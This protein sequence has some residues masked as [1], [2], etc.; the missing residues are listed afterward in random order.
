M[1]WETNDII[2]I[3]KLYITLYNWLLYLPTIILYKM[4]SRYSENYNFSLLMSKPLLWGGKLG[5]D[6]EARAAMP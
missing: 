3:Y 2:Y 4:H 6:G 1:L 5:E